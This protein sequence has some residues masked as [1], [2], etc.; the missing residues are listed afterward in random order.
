MYAA[1][2]AAAGGLTTVI[3][4]SADVADAKA[5]S[6]ATGDEVECVLAHH[7]KTGEVAARMIRRTKE[8]PKPPERQQW[9]KRELSE[10]TNVIK[11]AKGPDGTR[12]F[13]I[14]RGRPV[15]AAATPAASGGDAI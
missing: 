11:Y 2:A 6:L 8:A 9:V 1:A 4:Y 15:A 13:A 7:P 10:R 12:G 5:V 3:F 14:G